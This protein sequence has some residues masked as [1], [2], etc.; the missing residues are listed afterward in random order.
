MFCRENLGRLDWKIYYAVPTIGS[1]YVPR[2]KKAEAVLNLEA[3]PQFDI[4]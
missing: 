1:N 3:D 2:Y 4:K